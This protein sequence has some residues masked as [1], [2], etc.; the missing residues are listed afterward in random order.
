M[1]NHRIA[2][3]LLL[4]LFSALNVVAARSQIRD[5]SVS[6]PFFNPTLGQTVRIAFVAGIAGIARVTILDRDRFAIR[7]L[8]PVHV[9]Q[10]FVEIEWD[11]RDDRSS[12]VP[13]EAWNVRIELGGEIYDPSL[14]FVPVAED[15]QP[16]AYSRIDGVLSY[17]LTRPSRVHIE[18]GQAKRDGNGHRSEGPILKTI[19]NR[20]PRV[21]GSVVERWNGF[22][23]SGTI[24]VSDLTDFV[25]GM[26]ATSLPDNSILTRGNRQLAFLEYAKARRPASALKAVKRTAATHHHMGLN[27]FEDRS[28]ALDVKRT[29]AKDGALQLE[30]KISGTNSAHFVQQPGTVT[31]YVDSDR[32]VLRETPSSPLVVSIPRN[33]LGAG[34]RR[35]VVNWDSEYGPAAV[36]SFLVDI[37][38]KSAART[39]VAR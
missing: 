25:I 2:C 23:E 16:R 21:A 12:V 13:D 38:S 33:K 15:P 1:R 39:G 10:G 17:R 5:V 20:E 3:G 18:A 7:T 34:A 22:D 26:V 28:P 4:F 6:P 8:A 30:L 14:D 35:I 19:V 29:W 11:G 31:V 27:A 36:N 32:V 24:R 37:P 9:R